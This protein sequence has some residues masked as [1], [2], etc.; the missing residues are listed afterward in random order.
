MA[1]RNSSFSFPSCFLGD[2]FWAAAGGFGSNLTRRFPLHPPSG[3]RYA[4]ARVME[5]LRL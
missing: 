4:S 2:Y 5:R 3:A 1:Y